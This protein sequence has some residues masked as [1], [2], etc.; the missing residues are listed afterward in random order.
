MK[1][2]GG[3]MGAVAAMS[4]AIPVQAATLAFDDL[5]NPPALTDRL[6]LMTANGGSLDY[7]GVIWDAR[8]AVVGKDY[9]TDAGTSGSPFFGRPESG[10]YFLS[11]D[12]S[13]PL[14]GTGITLTTTQ[15]LTGAWFGRNEYY[16]FGGGA[17]QITITALS[18]ATE[19][20]SIV[21]DLP[22]ATPG[23]P[24]PL[25][26][27]DTSVFLTYAGITGYR[28]DCR[29]PHAEPDSETSANWVADSFTFV[30]VPEPGVSGLLAAAAAGVAGRSSLRRRRGGRSLLRG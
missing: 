2:T 27:V 24:E 6:D 10:D 15:V 29:N 22:L 5:S 7:G 19:R 1:T 30:A 20:G 14:F 25:S 4:L 26:F 23:E 18:G 21:F 17:D 13:A 3:V 28:I 8:I 16:G 11:Q 9:R 12:T